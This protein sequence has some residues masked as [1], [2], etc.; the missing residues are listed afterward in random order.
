MTK[1]WKSSD[2]LAKRKWPIITVFVNIESLVN[3]VR[4]VTNSNEIND[5]TIQGERK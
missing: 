1:Q 3:Q 5:A 4:A 2:L